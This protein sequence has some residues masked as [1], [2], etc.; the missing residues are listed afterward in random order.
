LGANISALLTASDELLLTFYNRW[1][2]ELIEIG[3]CQVEEGSIRLVGIEMGLAGLGFKGS[4]RLRVFA[5]LRV[6]DR[7]SAEGIPFGLGIVEEL[8]DR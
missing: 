8:G 3:R 2:V 1:E 4:N 5:E 6:S 7:K